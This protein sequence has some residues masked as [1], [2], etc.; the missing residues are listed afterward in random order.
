MHR[1]EDYSSNPPSPEN[2]QLDTTTTAG[3]GLY[4]FAVDP[5]TYIV[6]FETPAGFAFSPQDQGGDEAL[7]S[8]ADTSTGWTTSVRRPTAKLR[9]MP[10]D[11]RSRRR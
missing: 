8:D 3:G 5:G 1:R 2:L 9:T 7:D 4:S 10:Q 6:E 11:R